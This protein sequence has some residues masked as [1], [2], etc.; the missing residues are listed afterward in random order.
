VKPPSDESSTRAGQ[1]P[2][3]LYAQPEQSISPS[4]AMTAMSTGDMMALE[5]GMSWMEKPVEKSWLCLPTCD[6]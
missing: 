3:P 4:C 2:P 6:E 5:T 1:R